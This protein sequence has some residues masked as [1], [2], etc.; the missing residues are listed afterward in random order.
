M[1]MSYSISLTSMLFK[2]IAHVGPFKHV[3]EY[4]KAAML[5]IWKTWRQMAAAAGH[6]KTRVNTGASDEAYE[7]E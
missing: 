3:G 2:N 7:C 1:G 6:Y 5:Q 4:I